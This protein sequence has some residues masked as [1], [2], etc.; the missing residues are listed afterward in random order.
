[1]GYIYKGNYMHLSTLLITLI[2]YVQNLDLSIETLQ[3]IQTLYRS[4]EYFPYHPDIFFSLSGHFLDSQETF[5]IIGTL[6]LK[7]CKI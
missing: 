3:I 7:I 4:S 5:Q 6:W 2:E 1:M